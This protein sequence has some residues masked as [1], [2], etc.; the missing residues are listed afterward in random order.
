MPPTVKPLF[1]ADALRPRLA[2]FVPPPTAL[3]AR[4]KLRGWAALLA[5]PAGQAKKETELLPG[6]VRDLFEDALGYAGPPAPGPTLK[7]EALVKVGGKFADAALGRFGTGAAVYAAVLEGK[8][9]RDPLDRPFGGR[10]L[11]AVEQALRYAVELRCDWYLVTNL[12]Q[13]RLYHKGHDT[14]TYE[15]FDL[16][17]LAA[18]D[19]AFA[20]FVFLLGAER[21]APASGV[22]HLDALLSE[23]KKVQRELTAEFYDEYQWTRRATLNQLRAANPDADPRRLL[24]ASQKLL[25]RLLFVAFC[26]DRGLLPKGVIGH[27]YAH[28]DPFTPRPVWDN[29]RGLFR[30]VD[31]GNPAMNIG[32]YNGGLFAPDAFLDALSVP[33]AVCDGFKRLSEYE[34][35]EGDAEGRIVDVEILGHIFE[36]SISDLEGLE[37]SLAGAPEPLTAG[38][39]GPSRRKR[40]GAFYT[41][42]FVTR[43]IVA[44]TL[45]PVLRDRRATL[46]LRHQTEAAGT[47]IAALAEPAAFDDAALNDPRRRALARFWGAWLDELETIRVVDP[48]CGSGAFLIEAFDQLRVEY[49]RASGFLATLSGGPTLFDFSRTILSK[50]LF[51]VDLN[52]E[53][54]AVARLSCW[55]KT[56][57]PGKPLTTLDATIR[58]GNSVLGDGATPA[59][60]WA[61]WFPEVTAVGGFDCVIGNPPYVRQEW[62][63]ADKPRLREHYKAF[64]GAADL[65]VYFYELGLNLLRPGGRLGYVVTNKWMRAGYGENL[66]AL[67]AESAWVESV[68]DL[69][70]NKA[71]FP[72]A[73]VFPCILVAQKPR[74]EPPPANAV[75]CSIPREQFRVDDLSRQVRE[76][77]VSV[78]RERFGA[79]PW[80]LEPPGVEALMAKIRASGVP[81]REFIKASPIYGIKTGFNEAF[82]ID[83]PTKD[84]LVVEDHK[85]AELF[86]RYLRGQDVDRWQSEW[87]GLWMIAMKSSANQ[88]WPWTGLEVSE[89]ES[90]FRETYPS[91]FAHFEKH[92]AGLLA[93]ANS[94]HYWWELSGMGTWPSYD[95]PKMMYQ[96]ITWSPSFGIDTA[97]TLCNNTVYF[98]PSADL[99]LLASLNSPP[100]W[101]LMWRTAQHGKDEALR[102]FTDY[103]NAFPIPTPTDATR[104]AVEADVRRLI[105]LAGSRAAGLR[106]VL[107]WLRAEFAI[108]KPSNRLAD[109]A[110][111][112]PEELVAEVRKLR[113][114]RQPLSVAGVKRLGEAYAESVEPLRLADAEARSL[115]RRVADAVTAAY[116]L[117]PDEAKLMWATAPPRMPAGRPGD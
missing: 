71:V 108:D 1:R 100:A 9:P 12:G 72:D 110:S 2:N 99:W 32:A 107:A 109:M 27:A 36:K 26:E 14:L 102:L 66:R 55:I 24:A 70:H 8:G 114:K 58:Q 30:S 63:S 45:G 98:L 101:W 52:G 60:S 103:L 76:Q 18:D 23:T 93:R 56:A 47:A 88:K 78:P 22:C 112:S 81:L 106:D 92:R 20:R 83:T 105:D 48:S 49:E 67:Y 77:G 111:L 61:A 28:A 87:A 46:R 4:D 17:D 54:V 57:E 91:L 40:D 74:A 69:G 104:A 96:D 64:D 13:T 3:A 84:R 10:P 73:D 79:S 31:V 35:G 16:A 50:N 53:A 94:V 42:A 113:G 44:E 85:C 75:V 97:H 37:Q 59:E 115:E 80:S 68:L 117:T 29:F 62:I 89:A 41:P 65:Y 39:A 25:D 33:D 38:P 19:A 5:T 95:V 11:S 86:R 51:G 6:F 82:L 7:R 15:R 34:Y 21:V 43:Y 116:G 90:V